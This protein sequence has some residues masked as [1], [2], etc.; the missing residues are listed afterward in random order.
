[1]LPAAPG[2]IAIAGGL[3]GQGD[4]EGSRAGI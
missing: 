4:R 1:M 2:P 3:E